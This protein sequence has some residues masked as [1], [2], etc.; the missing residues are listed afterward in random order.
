MGIHRTKLSIAFMLVF[1]SLAF[2]QAPKPASP[3]QKPEPPTEKQAKPGPQYSLRVATKD[4]ISISLKAEKAPLAK[5]AA[6]L[7]RKLKIPVLVSPSA[8]DHEVTANFADLTLEPALYSLAPQVY[9]DYE[10]NH[11]P[12]GQSRPIGIYLNGFED[13]EPAVGA[14]VP[15]KSEVILIEGNTEDVPEPVGDEPTKILYEQNSL[16]VTAK[17][18]PLSVVLY[19]VAHE[20]HIPFE[21]KWETS[22]LIDVDFNQLPLEEAIPRL[23]P[24]LRLFIRSNLQKFER[25]P[26]RLVLVRPPAA[27]PG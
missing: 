6:E 16:T 20:L 26:F 1:G 18:Q 2:G 3:S 4:L 23:S 21:L 14:I 24:H 12:G 9:V 25:R 7:S 17:R 15:A 27:D 19:K 13:P 10:I 5:I 8:Q 11:A 22:E